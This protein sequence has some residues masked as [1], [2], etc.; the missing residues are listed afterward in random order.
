MKKSIQ[1]VFMFCLIANY[2]Y[3]SKYE[4]AMASALEKLYAANNL[5]SYL[6]AS[7]AFERI[8]K[9]EKEKWRPYYYA[10]LG[11]IWASHS[12]QD[13]DKID[14][15]LDQAQRF[16]DISEELSPNNDEIITLQGYIYM[17]KVVVDP[18][19]RGPEF[20][21]LAMQEFGKATGM[22]ANN[23][24]ALLLLAR[25]KMGTDQ[26]FGNDLS[27]SC[28]MISKAVQMF[29]KQIVKSKLDPSWGKEMAEMF[30][31]ECKSN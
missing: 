9:A 16:V 29:H 6:I 23:P 17:M 31:V 5:E 14:G 20:S 13:V 12:V 4:S 18:P 22:N 7:S 25:M 10:G 15:Y 21:G 19:S 30:E 27:E 2:T 26:F 8:G 28:G 24:R 3:A 11:Y 1:L